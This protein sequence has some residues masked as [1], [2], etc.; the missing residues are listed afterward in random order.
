MTGRQ[1]A[2]VSLRLQGEK[3]PHHATAAMTKPSLVILV[4]GLTQLQPPE[5]E[6][7]T[8]PLRRRLLCPQTQEQTAAL[9][10][11]PLGGQKAWARLATQ[12][13]DRPRMAL[14]AVQGRLVEDSPANVSQPTRPTPPSPRSSPVRF[15]DDRMAHGPAGTP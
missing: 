15:A 1:Q 14:R 11:A 6:D 8:L 2:V 13:V 10:V 4:P 9:H 3:H 7:L 12:P 5:V